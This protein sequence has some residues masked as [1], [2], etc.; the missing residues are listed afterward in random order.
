MGDPLSIAAGV[1][2]IISLGLTVSSGL[3]NYYGSWKDSPSNVSTMCESLET[4]TK[5]FEILHERI[6]HPL[7]DSKI[8]DMVTESIIS[9]AAGVQKLQSKLDKIRNVK[10]AGAFLQRAQYP[11]RQK[12]LMNLHQTISDLRD[13]LGLAA[14]TLQ[15]DVSTMALHRLNQLDE[16]TETLVATSEAFNTE[17]LD[18]ISQ[19]RLGQEQ[20][21]LR[22]MSTEERDVI[23]WL[24]PLDFVAKQNDA[25]NRRQHGTGRWLLESSEF[26]SWISTAG[27]VLWCPGMRKSFC[28]FKC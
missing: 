15:L 4:L 25:L 1:A 24:S 16:R 8:V 5:T 26:R 19:L 13:N 22:W 9:C 2:G 23:N 28:V 21:K 11:F 20:E 7:L 17:A 18:G 14:S 12:T 6:R 3:L 27:K 10:P